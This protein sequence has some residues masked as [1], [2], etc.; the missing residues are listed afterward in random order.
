ML[1]GTTYNISSRLATGSPT[2]TQADSGGCIFSFTGP[3][4]DIPVYTSGYT[5]LGPATPGGPSQTIPC[6]E[7]LFEAVRYEESLHPDSASVTSQAFSH[8]N[9]TL[10]VTTSA[11]SISG[12]TFTDKNLQGCYAGTG[13]GVTSYMVPSGQY[14][15]NVHNKSATAYAT[16]NETVTVSC[17]DFM[18]LPYAPF[19]IQSSFRRSPVCSSYASWYEKQPILPTDYGHGAPP[20]VFESFGVHSWQ[21]CGK[22]AFVLPTVSVYY[23]PTATWENCRSIALAPTGSPR[24]DLKI[25]VVDGSTL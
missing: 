25:A 22:C 10:A 20:G 4:T 12:P 23:F 6:G 15:P 24:N 7:F 9:S 18:Q 11:P 17:S 3:H 21:C 19:T 2:S 5:V 13:L 14:L 1:A 16:K 8:Q